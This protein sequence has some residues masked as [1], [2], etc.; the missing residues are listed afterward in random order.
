MKATE[1]P[2]RSGL[3]VKDRTFSGGGYDALKLI[4]HAVRQDTFTEQYRVQKFE[5]NSM[6]NRRQISP[7]L[8]LLT[9]STTAYERR[10][11]ITTKP[12]NCLTFD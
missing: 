7:G 4:E 5:L 6:L 2:V 1:A 8:L 12:S 9:V 11:R 10:S 3:G